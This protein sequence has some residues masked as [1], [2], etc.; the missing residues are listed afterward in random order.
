MVKRIYRGISSPL[1]WALRSELE[2]IKQELQ[3]E[4]KKELDLREKGEC[5]NIEL[6]RHHKSLDSTAAYVD[7]AMAKTES[8]AS[9]EE[10]LTAALRRTRKGGGLYCEFGVYSGGTINHIAG[11]TQSPVYGFD[12]FEGLPEGWYGLD[13]GHFAVD[14]LPKVL[15]NVRLIKGWFN[16]TLPKFAAEHSEKAEFF[17]VDCD[18]YSS[19]KMVF[20]AMGPKITAGTV[21]VFDEYFNYPDWENGEFKAFK[22]FISSSKLG[23]EYIGYNRYGQQA[24]VLIT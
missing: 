2:K 20:E 23:Y 6:R 24:G 21:I 12:S 18:L 5:Q 16:E 3:A 17:H 19:T 7:R 13:K 1:R 11:N 4:F 10:L 14:G 8:F 9:K 15:P 22:E